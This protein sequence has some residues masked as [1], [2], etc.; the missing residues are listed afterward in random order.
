M[1][2]RK[3]TAESTLA[4]MPSAMGHLAAWCPVPRP[5]HPSGSTPRPPVPQGHA[6][7]Q[8]LAPGLFREAVLIV[9]GTKSTGIDHLT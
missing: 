6:S 3:G 5:L 1:S 4:D 9:Y 7:A 8:A 2:E